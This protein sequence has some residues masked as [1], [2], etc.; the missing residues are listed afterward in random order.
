MG[1]IQLR[2]LP[3]TVPLPSGLMLDNVTADNGRILT[4][5]VFSATTNTKL[6]SRDLRRR[7]FSGAFKYQNF[8]LKFTAPAGRLLEFRTYWYGGSYVRQDNIV[9]R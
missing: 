1:R 8:D 5:E 2:L 9:I 3:E 7:E 6:A 4:I